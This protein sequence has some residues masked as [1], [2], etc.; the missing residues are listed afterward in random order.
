[1]EPKVIAAQF[2]DWAK[3]ASGVTRGSVEEAE[4][5][6]ELLRDHLDIDD[7]RDLQPADLQ[8]L[9]LDVYPR[10]APVLRRGDLEEVIPS[11][12]DLLVFLR[13]PGRVPS[14]RLT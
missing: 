12:R 2:A 4:L 6:L 13:D 1:M 10:N 3:K 14:A 11:M 5:L 7:P 9:L 8:D